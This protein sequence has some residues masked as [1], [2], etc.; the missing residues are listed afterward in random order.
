MVGFPA[1]LPAQPAEP[2]G[3]LCAE[4]LGFYLGPHSYLYVLLSFLW[5][6]RG[7]LSTAHLR[8]AGVFC[9][10]LSPSSTVA[11]GSATFVLTCWN[12]RHPSHMHY[13]TGFNCFLCWG[14]CLGFLVW[15]LSPLLTL[16]RGLG[17]MLL[18][19][20]AP[21]PQYTLLWAFTCTAWTPSQ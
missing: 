18:T 19:L 4:V 11:S 3:P 9:S 12:P 6:H 13:P 5:P 8:V 21:P 14:F 7:A 2:R 1:L 10:S 20:T 17:Y 16:S 15:H